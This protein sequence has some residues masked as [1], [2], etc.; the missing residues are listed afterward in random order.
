MASLMILG[1]A[2][3][4]VIGLSL[5]LLGGGGSIL[6]VPV[7]IYCLGYS[8]KSAVPMSLV[9]VGV[10]SL[11]GVLRHRRDGTLNLPAA[12]AFGPPAIAGALVG[13]GLGV[14][15]DPR[16]QL[17]LF[18]VV[19]L[20]A[21]VMMFF[22]RSLLGAQHHARRG[23]LPIMVVGAGVGLLTGF[24]G[25][26]GGFAYVPAL[27]LL[28]GLAMK[29]AVGTSLVLIVL[30]CG[31]GLAMYQGSMTLDWRAVGL[32]TALALVGVII[33]TWLVRYVRQDHL[34]RGF[35]VFLLL[36]GALVLLRGR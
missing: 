1:Y 27:V 10:T 31:S 7:L 24:V 15:A 4:V 17:T 28:G 6:T 2:L 36:M 33:G 19:M 13:A 12:L 9:V 3:A 23:L 32:F 14:R 35:A 29:E 5:G 26:G 34:R 16:L 21:A 25:V 8:V 11:V 18:A 20:V 30:S 22:R